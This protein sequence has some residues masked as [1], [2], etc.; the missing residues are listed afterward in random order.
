MSGLGRA[1]RLVFLSHSLLIGQVI[2]ERR[3]LCA[4]THASF[5]GNDV[6]RWNHTFRQ[7]STTLAP[8]LRSLVL[9]V[10]AI[11]PNFFPTSMGHN[12]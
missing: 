3:R 12:S 10:P 9:I 5:S 11:P 7:V 2:P 8:T 1:S 4:C 6:G